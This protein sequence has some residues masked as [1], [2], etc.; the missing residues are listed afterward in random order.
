[1]LTVFKMFK[2]DF[3]LC[4]K[5]VQLKICVIKDYNTFNTRSLQ[6]GEPYIETIKEK[7]ILKSKKQKM[8]KLHHCISAKNLPILLENPQSRPIDFFTCFRCHLDEQANA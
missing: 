8:R 4:V 2:K 6:K 1:M 5:H 3:F 7:K